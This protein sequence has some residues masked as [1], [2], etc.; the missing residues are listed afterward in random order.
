MDITAGKSA[1]GAA[2]APPTVLSRAARM[3]TRAVRGVD[4][5]RPAFDLGLRLY[6]A[7]V[8]FK[9]G[10]VKI[11]SWEA[12]VSLFEN[13]YEV[14]LLPSE[15]A[16]VLGT[17]AELCFPLLLALGLGGRFAA[18][19]LSVLNVVAVLSYP[20]LSEAGLKDHMLWGALLAVGFF[21]GPGRLSLDHLIRRK[22]IG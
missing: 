1:F 9:A 5:L 15:A 20:D 7:E 10:L 17:G 11:A 12:T 13:V 22:F 8:F 2:A 16:A 19:S 14:P 4:F 6:V 3:V 18:A 21:H